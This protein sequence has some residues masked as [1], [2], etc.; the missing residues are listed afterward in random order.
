MSE[1]RD[2]N[3]QPSTVDTL[4]A[5][6]LAGLAGL[7]RIIPHP[8]NMTPLNAMGLFGG[9]RLPARWALTLPLAVMVASDLVIWQLKQWPPFNPFVYGSFV[10]SV[11]LGR[12]LTRIDLDWKVA[13]ATL[14]CSLQFFLITNFGVWLGASDRPD[15]IPSGDAFVYDTESPYAYPLIRYARTPTGLL[16]CYAHGLSFS[17]VDRAKAWPFGFFGNLL[18]G[19]LFFSGMLFGAHALLTRRFSQ[20]AVARAPSG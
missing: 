3:R 4:L 5:A 19:D 10:L 17:E 1:T 18:A 14:A 6:G 16:A 11:L 13:A 8:F 15:R 20:P 12:L 7:V 2:D 9:A